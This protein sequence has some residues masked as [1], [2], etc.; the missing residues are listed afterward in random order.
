MGG[1]GQLI[2]THTHTTTTTTT[3]TL[4]Y[5]AIVGSAL[6]LTSQAAQTQALSSLQTKFKESWHH[7]EMLFCLLGPLDG[8]P[9]CI[10]ERAASSGLFPHFPLLGLR[11]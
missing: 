2:N 3:T 6:S 5:G 8:F 7:P 9:E 4:L 1:L 11:G 10:G